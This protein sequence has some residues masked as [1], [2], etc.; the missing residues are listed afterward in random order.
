MWAQWALIRSKMR[1]FAIFLSLD[2]TFFLKLHT[3]IACNIVSHLVEVKSTKKIIGTQI[4]TKIGCEIRFFA[5]YSSLV[6]FFCFSNCIQDDT[7]EQC[8]TTCLLADVK[9]LQK[10]EKSDFFNH[11]LKFDSLVFLEIAQDDSLE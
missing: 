10:R 11:F 9:S 7:L 3:V 6:H 5:I 8:L 1:F 2:R 4:W